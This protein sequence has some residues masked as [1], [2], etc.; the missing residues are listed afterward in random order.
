MPGTRA[1]RK[2]IG[3]TAV[4]S[5]AAVSVL[6]LAC[7]T[8]ARGF[9]KPAEAWGQTFFA[10][11]GSPGEGRLADSEGGA[12]LAD[13]AAQRG[14]RRRREEP[15]SPKVSVRPGPAGGLLRATT[16]HDGLERVYYIHFPRNSQRKTPKPAVLILHGG[17]GA[18]APTMASR[19]GMNEIADRENFLAVYPQGID[20]QWNDGRGK[21]F[22]RAKDNTQIDDV[23]FLRAV[24]ERLTAEH[25]ADPDRIYVMGLSNGGMMTHRLG[26]ELGQRL[27]GIAAIIANLPVNLA[28]QRPADSPAVLIMNGTADPMMPW[29]GGPVR[30]LG[31]EYGEVL[32]TN[33]TVLFWTR[34]AQLPSKPKTEKIEDRNKRDGSTVEVDTFS[35]AGNPREVILYRIVGGGHQLPGGNTP[36]RPQL[37][38]PKNMDIHGSEE[39]WAFFRRHRL[40]DRHGANA[41]PSGAAV[42]APRGAEGPASS[43]MVHTALAGLDPSMPFL[44]RSGT[45]ARA[46]TAPWRPQVK[47]VGDPA[48]SYLNV[49]MTGDGR[50]MVWFEGTAGGSDAGIVWHCG[51]DPSTGDLIPPDGRGFRAFESTSWARANPG[52]DSLGVYYVGADRQGRLILVRPEGPAQGRVS[53]LPIP[54]DPL[55]RAIYPTVLPDRRGGAVLFI[56]NEKNPG[57]GTR[58]NGNSWV[59]LQWASLSNPGPVQVVERQPTPPFGFAP[60]DTGFVRWM[61]HRMIMTFGGNSPGGRKVKVRGYD[62]DNPRS[63]AFDLIDNGHTH[64]DP[65][66]ALF[67]GYE[68]IFAGIDATAESFVYRRPAHSPASAPFELLHRL[69]PPE[70]SL[71][72][73]SLAQSHEPFEILGRLFT[74][75]QVNDQGRGFFDTTFQ[76]NGEIWLADLTAQPPRQW[77]IAPEVSGPAAEPEPLVTPFGAWV[78]YNR[79]L[80]NSSGAGGDEDR[81]RSP[82]RGPRPLGRLRGERV[83]ADMDVPSQSMR[84]GLFRADLPPE[85]VR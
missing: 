31:Q 48:V 3:R 36:D 50:Y 74:V 43:P 67:G 64:I 5:S 39:A 82:V 8:Q 12:S 24:I 51:I 66:P 28:A 57:A 68:Y 33:E 42:P 17:G 21:T 4:L 80:Q 32:S 35:A 9:M 46:A 7:A 61:R 13:R 19:T 37:L 75:Y 65:Y 83:Q 1:P 55:R 27:A 52:L 84:F 72:Q 45:A 14:L 22:R 56:R 41:L 85:A 53:A 78:F 47:Q 11:A 23:G 10:R 70:S 54:A 60:M 81:R 63:G 26:I 20:G 49:E 71:R 2:F 38:G 30:V 62:A 59:E 40:Q 76:N 73:P 18:D 16:T 44:R 58:A 69:T 34:A 25:A 6:V 77:R 29:N 15:T 79:P